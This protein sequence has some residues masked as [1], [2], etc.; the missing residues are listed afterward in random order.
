MMFYEGSIG[1]EDVTLKITDGQLHR[2]GL[3]FEQRI[4]MALS[5]TLQCDRR[6]LRRL[7]EWADCNFLARMLGGATK[8]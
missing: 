6:V 1:V 2:N 4:E 5:E 8:E 3:G 7:G